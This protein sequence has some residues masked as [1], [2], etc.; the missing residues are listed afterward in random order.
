MK[1]EK[2]D[3]S[4]TALCAMTAAALGLFGVAVLLTAMTAKKRC[5]NPES[6]SETSAEQ[7]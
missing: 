1:K 4:N 6:C 2:C 7:S 3:L 5:S